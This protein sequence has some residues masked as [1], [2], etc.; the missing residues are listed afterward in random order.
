MEDNTMITGKTVEEAIEIA[1][2]VLDADRSEVEIE[3]LSRGKSGFLGF[4]AEMAK[5][6]ASRIPQVRILVSTAKTIVDELFDLMDITAVSTIKRPEFDSPDTYPLEVEGDDSGLLIGRR[7]ETLKAIQF[8]LNRILA[9]RVPG[10]EGRVALD[11]EQYRF[12]RMQTLTT[13]ANRTAQR[14]GHYGVAITLEPMPASERRA[15]HVALADH[16]TVITQ[17]VGQGF[18]RQVSILP[19]KIESQPPRGGRTRRP[20]PPGIQR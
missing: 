11:V 9:K 13:L 12:R 15:I 17:S 16:P 6:R 3:V 8:L 5:V 14:V 7:G 1:L 10:H 18:E 2:R 4:G 19:K 20:P